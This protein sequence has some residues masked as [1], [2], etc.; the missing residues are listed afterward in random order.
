MSIHVNGDHGCVVLAVVG[1]THDRGSRD[2]AHQRIEEGRFRCSVFQA[3]ENRC[4]ALRIRRE[5]AEGLERIHAVESVFILQPEKN[6]KLAHLEGFEARC[7]A[8]TIA[9]AEESLRCQSLENTPLRLH[10]AEDLGGAS[11]MVASAWDL[12]FGHEVLAQDIADLGEFANDLL[13]PEF[14]GLM[15]DYEVHF[16]V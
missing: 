9:E 11:E 4:I 8:Q 2:P 7:G 6:L 14:E 15:D 13:E 10:Q 1:G 3:G 16:I 5:L 12:V